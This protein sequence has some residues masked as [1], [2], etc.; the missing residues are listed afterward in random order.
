MFYFGIHG[1]GLRSLVHT[2]DQSAQLADQEEEAGPAHPRQPHHLSTDNKSLGDV[3]EWKLTK[4]TKHVSWF[5]IL[6]P[7]R[8]KREVAWSFERQVHV[9]TGWPWKQQRGSVMKRCRWAILESVTIQ[10]EQLT[11]F[12]C[13]MPPPLSPFTHPT[14]HVWGSE[15]L[16]FVYLSIF[17]TGD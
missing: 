17:C 15:M 16:L 3:D 13:R 9:L 2:A 5:T 14:T 11:L 7:G 6:T 8:V 1:F 10:P 4:N 12:G